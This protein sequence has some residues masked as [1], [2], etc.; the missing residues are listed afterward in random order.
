MSLCAFSGSLAAAL[1]GSLSTCQA[2]ALCAEVKWL[3][4]I[5]VKNDF[6][7][8]T[9]HTAVKIKVRDFGFETGK[10]LVYL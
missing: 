5:E 2:L 6:S 4:Y 8:F 3:L 9:A 10:H 7:T 1:A